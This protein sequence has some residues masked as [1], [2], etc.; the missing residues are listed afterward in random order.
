MYQDNRSSQ[1]SKCT[2]LLPAIHKQL[3]EVQNR[4]ELGAK[5]FNEKLTLAVIEKR[6]VI[7]L[8]DMVHTIQATKSRNLIENVHPLSRA[9]NNHYCVIDK[10]WIALNGKLEDLGDPSDEEFPHPYEPYFH[11]RQD[12]DEYLKERPTMKLKL[13]C[14][15]IQVKKWALKIINISNTGYYGIMFDIMD[16]KPTGEVFVENVG[17]TSCILY[18]KMIK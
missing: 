2:P 12:Y 5:V 10:S 6:P 11:F 7:V 8:C 16:F 14:E 13:E 18:E 1:A 3:S 4:H 17:D 15:I 9:R